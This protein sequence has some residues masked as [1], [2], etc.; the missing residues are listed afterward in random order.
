MALAQPCFDNIP[1]VKPD[2]LSEFKPSRID[3]SENIR[4]Y[5]GW[6]KQDWRKYKPHLLEDCAIFYRAVHI[7]GTFNFNT[8]IL[9]SFDLL[10]LR[11]LI[12]HSVRG[13]I[14]VVPKPANKIK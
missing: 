13:F 6:N 1:H 10:L 12:D 9:Y 4:L 5:M 7:E 8:R 14:Q 2:L 11:W 3:G